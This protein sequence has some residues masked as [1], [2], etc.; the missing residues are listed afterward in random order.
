MGCKMKNRFSHMTAKNKKDQQDLA[1]A[2]FM[3]LISAYEY[4]EDQTSCLATASDVKERLLMS[5][6]KYFSKMQEL[7]K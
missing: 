4:V 3:F 5:M 1:S 7:R 2:E 6:G